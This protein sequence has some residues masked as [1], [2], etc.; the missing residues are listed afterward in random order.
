MFDRWEYTIPANTAEADAIRVECKVSPGVLKSLIVY[1]PAGCHGLARCRIFI[2]ERPVAPRSA[3][4]FIA[5]EDM[6]VSMM[7]LEER[8][9]EDLPVLNWDVWNI[10]DTYDHTIWMSAEWTSAEEPY[11]KTTA[12][13]L[14]DFVSMMRRLIGV[15]R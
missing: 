3:K 5:A 7:Y 2:G 1:F 11:E 14:R 8:I 13:S 10:D 4:N 15:R 6:A 9:R 12:R